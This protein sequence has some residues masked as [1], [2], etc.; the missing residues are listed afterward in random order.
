MANARLQHRHAPTFSR[1]PGVYAPALLLM[2]RIYFPGVADGVSV[3]ARPLPP[4]PRRRCCVCVLSGVRER[5]QQTGVVSLG[6]NGIVAILHSLS[7]SGSRTGTRFGK[8]L[9]I[10]IPQR[11]VVDNQLATFLEEADGEA[12]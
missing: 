5:Q 2:L 12:R 9:E 7:I 6:W 1:G 10:S 4:P 3:A 8:V 11:P